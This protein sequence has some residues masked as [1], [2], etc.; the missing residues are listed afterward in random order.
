MLG[1]LLQPADT[2]SPFLA[3]A[4][5]TLPPQSPGE[6]SPFPSSSA[7]SDGSA[8]SATRSPATSATFCSRAVVVSFSPDAEKPSWLNFLAM[9]S[10]V[11]APC[12]PAASLTYA[13]LQGDDD[14]V[15]RA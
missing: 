2:Y 15:K 1:S 3:R 9:A 12:L 10:P 8:R 11:A 14:A 5:S 6:W 13:K 7:G 4:S